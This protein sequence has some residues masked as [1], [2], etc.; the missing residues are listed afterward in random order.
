MTALPVARR[1]AVI[2]VT[3]PAH[4]LRYLPIAEELERRD[5]EVLIIGREKDVTRQLLE[6]ST[7]QFVM[8]QSRVVRRPRSLSL[9]YELVTRVVRIRRIL[10]G[11]KPDVLLTSNPSGAIAA[12]AARIPAIFDTNDGRAAGAHHVLAATLADVITSP[13]SVGEDLGWR[14]IAYR[15]W[16]SLAWLH[17]E[18]S[19]SS[20]ALP[21]ALRHIPAEPYALVR[22]VAHAASHDRGVAGI[23]GT[24][25]AEIREIIESGG[26]GFV[27]SAET[28]SSVARTTDFLARSP[29][30]MPHLLERAAFV[31]TDSASVAEEA[32]M[33]GTPVYRIC[34]ERGRRRYL[35]QLEERHGLGRNFSLSERQQFLAEV[36]FAVDNHPALRAAAAEARR[37]LL[38]SHHD[39]VDWYADLVCRTMTLGRRRRRERISDLRALGFDERSRS[40][41]R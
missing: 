38:A 39:G 27:V 22:V 23:D 35:D 30:I 17:P 4:A 3:H 26:L 13:I 5:V 24:L 37:V 34:T 7:A 21:Q 6:A 18:R 28:G 16:K 15:S 14:H 1:R 8:I 33:L 29:E 19:R 2:E 40:A 41:R 12:W 32:S 10:R 36:A 9:L 11:I 20:G 31:V 25:M